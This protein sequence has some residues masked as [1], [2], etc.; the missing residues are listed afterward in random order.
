MA[1]ATGQKMSLG[2]SKRV[3][4]VTYSARTVD[5]A[6]GVFL[7]DFYVVFIISEQITRED[8]QVRGVDSKNR[9]Y[10]THTYVTDDPNL[11][12]YLI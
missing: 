5:A 4:T 7:P 11:S 2:V 9:E 8:R 6:C 10:H 1:C 3:P 12:N